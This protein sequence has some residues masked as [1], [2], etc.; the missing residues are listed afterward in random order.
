MN[1]YVV[2]HGSTLMN[3][4]DYIQGSIN[5]SLSDQGIKQAND[6]KEKVKDVSFDI[7]ISSPLKR[8]IETANIIVDDKYK[9]VT[10]DRLLERKM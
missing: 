3:E 7:C 10:D 2:R 4:Q 8:T 9:I 1:L 6:L 5:I